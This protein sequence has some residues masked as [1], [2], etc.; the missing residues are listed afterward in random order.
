[1]LE[2]GTLGTF[3]IIWLSADLAWT[4]RLHIFA[5]PVTQVRACQSR[6]LNAPCTRD[7]TESPLGV[8]GLARN[9]AG[10]SLPGIMDGEALYS[11][12]ETSGLAALVH[13]PQA[14]FSRLVSECFRC[15]GPIG[16]RYPKPNRSTA[17]GTRLAKEHPISTH[18]YTKG[19]VVTLTNSRAKN[20]PEFLASLD[21]LYLPLLA[22]VL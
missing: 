14:S 10:K 9:F 19:T 7:L 5:V 12:C 3:R 15:R 21:P 20:L 2:V 18:Y 11:H 1:M 13:A 8:G 22:F 17:F 6:S 16:T 4:V